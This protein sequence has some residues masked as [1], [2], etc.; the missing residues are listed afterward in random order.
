MG[1][2]FEEARGK[3]LVNQKK[4]HKLNPQWTTIAHPAEW[5]QQKGQEAPRTGEDLEH[6]ELSFFLMGATLT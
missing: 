3:W 4:A 1:K 5:L 2:R 6:V